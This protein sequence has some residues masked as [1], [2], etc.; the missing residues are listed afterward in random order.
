MNKQKDTKI[1]FWFFLLT[2]VIFCTWVKADNEQELSKPTSALSVGRANPFAEISKPKIPVGQ[3]VSRPLQSFEEQP[4]LFVET[5]TL[6]FLDAKNLSLAVANMS[7]PYGAIAINP[8][9]NSLILCDTKESLARILAEVRKAD[10]TPQQVAIEVVILD[11]QLDDDTQ[12]GV[13]WDIL[14][15][16]LYDISYRQ[17]FTVRLASTIEDSDTIGD[18]TRFNT[19]GTGGDFALI[20]GT[21][22]NIIHALQE[23]KDV[24]IL[25]SPRVLLI[26]G[27]TALIETVEE[28]PYRE[29]TETSGGGVLASVEFKEVGVKLNVTAI[30]T[31]DN[32][33]LLT[34]EP[35]QNV[36]T[37]VF[38]IDDI[39]IIDT[40]KAKTTLLLK[41]GEIV[42]MGG[43]RRKG[44]TKIREQIP[45]LGDLPVLGF[46]FGRDKVT[47]ENSELIVFLAPHIYRG[48]ELTEQELNKFNE[49][50]NRPML[51]IPN[52]K[53]KKDQLEGVNE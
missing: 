25:A 31:D 7:S 53:G 23:K 49:L 46:L 12:I 45:F 26:S 9:D 28:I 3:T 10:K 50:R 18:V 2:V 35:E 47:T 41:D 42:A 13:N 32:D 39:P 11:V 48:K 51:S 34:V 8:K 1:K 15:D 14:S 24:E 27:G 44:Q 21:V 37:G 20:S 40:R 29:Q 33:I 5:V 17:N 19:I 30:V 52:E 16:D 38:G 22:R 4:E 43:L 6:K 36:N